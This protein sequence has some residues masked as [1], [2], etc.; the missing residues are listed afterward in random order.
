M[1]P[2]GTRV[3]VRVAWRAC[4]ASS[5]S[6]R[7]RSELTRPRNVRACQQVKITC[8]AGQ[9][10]ALVSAATEA[11]GSHSAGERSRRARAMCAM[12]MDAAVRVARFPSS[13]AGQ[14]G[15]PG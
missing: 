13:P 14:A 1:Q 3:V 7:V 11:V 9:C 4:T 10:A 8:G 5:V 15:Q 2:A 6:L 12:V